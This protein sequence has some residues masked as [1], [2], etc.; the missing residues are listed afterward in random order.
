MNNGIDDCAICG[1][2]FQVAKMKDGKCDGCNTRFPGVANR[3]DLKKQRD[4]SSNK[5]NEGSFDSR[6]EKKVKDILSELGILSDC[7]CGKKFFKRSPA[8]KN[9][10]C[11]KET[12]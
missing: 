12:E 10:G 11:K 5:Y 7:T 6:V 2:K 1:E 9:C 4:E 3:E 8:Q